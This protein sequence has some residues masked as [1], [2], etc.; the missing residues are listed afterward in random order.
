MSADAGCRRVSFVSTAIGSQGM[1]L[2]FLPLFPVR[3]KTP[4][5]LSIEAFML[6]L[7]I[8]SLVLLGYLLVFHTYLCMCL[9]SP[10]STLAGLCSLVFTGVLSQADY[11]S[12][13]TSHPGPLPATSSK[14]KGLTS[15]VRGSCASSTLR[16][17]ENMRDG[18]A[19]G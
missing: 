3:T 18:K 2:L 6:L 10:L 13:P 8:I 7:A 15:T 16:P 9:P 14:P 12:H 11:F 19:V 1:S 4:V 5:V 17:G